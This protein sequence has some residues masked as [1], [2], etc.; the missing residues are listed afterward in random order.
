MTEGHTGSDDYDIIAFDVSF[1]LCAFHG[2]VK[3]IQYVMASMTMGV[4]PQ[5]RFNCLATRALVVQAM[6]SDCGR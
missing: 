6:M 3:Q 5:E 4:T 2:V 1:F